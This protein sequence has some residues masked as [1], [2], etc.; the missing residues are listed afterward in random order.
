MDIPVVTKEERLNFNVREFVKQWGLN[1]AKGGGG[2]MWREVW[3]ETVSGVYK[4]ILGALFP[5]LSVSWTSANGLIHDVGREEPK[6]GLEPKYN[7][8][9]ELKDRKRYV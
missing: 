9:A 6:F 3:D 8:Y 1:A 5:F 7:P 4:D 2:H